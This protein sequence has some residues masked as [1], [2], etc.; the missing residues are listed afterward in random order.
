MEPTGAEYVGRV[1]SDSCWRGISEKRA[2][3]ESTVPDGVKAL[4]I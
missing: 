2:L 3:K 1:L 4:I